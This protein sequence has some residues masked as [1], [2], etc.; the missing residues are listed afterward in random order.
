[1]CN[2]YFLTFFMR[3]QCRML[4]SLRHR[5]NQSTSIASVPSSTTQ[6]MQNQSASSSSSSTMQR[7]PQKRTCAGDQLPQCERPLIIPI[8]KQLE[9]YPYMKSRKVAPI[10]GAL[11]K[12]FY[13]DMI[14]PKENR[15]VAKAWND[16]KWSPNDDTPSG[17]IIMKSEFWLRFKH[18]PDV[19][20]QEANRILDLNLKNLVRHMMCVLRKEAVLK[21]YQ[22]KNV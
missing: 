17:A 9:V 2:L 14:G 21:V 22:K 10:L 13:P 3:M 18:A 12:L 20:I 19:D 6:P 5:P 4:K 7:R 11:L 8:G 15:R 16:Y 1:M